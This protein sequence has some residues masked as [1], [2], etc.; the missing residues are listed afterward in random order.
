MRP[1]DAERKPCADRKKPCV[2]SWQL[3]QAISP[4]R[5]QRRSKNRRLPRTARAPVRTL[6]GG[7]ASARGPG[8]KTG[9]CRTDDQRLGSRASVGSGRSRAGSIGARATGTTSAALQCYAPLHGGTRVKS[10]RS[11]A[12]ATHALAGLDLGAPGVQ[13]SHITSSDELAARER[14]RPGR[15]M[16]VHAR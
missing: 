16:Q 2:W 6:S 1:F 13:G 9:G 7:P 8:V 12:I 11:G 14:A 15:T 3:A 4:V 5:E 10:E